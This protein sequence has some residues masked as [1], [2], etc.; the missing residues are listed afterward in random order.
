MIK[1]L[2]IGIFLA[3]SGG[4]QAQTG[5]DQNNDCDYTNA[6]QYDGWGWNATSSQSCAPIVCDGVYQDLD[7]D[8]FGLKNNQTCVVTD[9]SD[10]KPVFINRETSAQVNLTRAYWDGNNDIAN[11]QLACEYHRFNDETSKYEL[12]TRFQQVSLS[13]NTY[14]PGSLEYM[15]L[16]I[17][18]LPPY[19]GWVD[20]GIASYGAPK[21]SVSDG[22]ISGNTV[23]QGPYFEMITR[24]DGQKAVRRWGG[25]N[26]I[27]ENRFA[28]LVL[29][30]DNYFECRDVSGADLIPTGQR[31]VST[32]NPIALADLNLRVEN[33]TPDAPA[34]KEVVDAVTGEVIELRKF[35]WNYNNDLAGRRFSCSNYYVRSG[36]IWT[37]DPLS[38]SYEL[39]YRFTDSP[40]DMPHHSTLQPDGISS[41]TTHNITDGVGDTSVL[42]GIFGSEYAHVTEPRGV[43]FWSSNGTSY[44]SCGGIQPTVSTINTT[45]CDYTDADLYN[46]W[47][48]NSQTQQSCAPLTTECIDSDGDGW[49]WDGTKSCRVAPTVTCVDTDGDGWGWDGNNSCRVP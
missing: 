8:G 14:I 41:V 9:E 24:A 33:P 38:H 21:W 22:V 35:Q 39:P 29:S 37:L 43:Q 15:H 6:Q 20:L 19:E 44:T 23:L 2:S 45:S 26:T 36:G 10:R 18:P 7:G 47:G 48:W 17:A 4:V 42:S 11:R 12:E 3:L 28:N 30:T 13:Y 34:I 25:G 31:G 1:V 16:P 40:N 46:G 32:A 49:G 5:S 27:V